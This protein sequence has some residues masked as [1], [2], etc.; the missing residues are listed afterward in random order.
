MD[1]CT[2]YVKAQRDYADQEREGDGI[3]QYAQKFTSTAGRHDG[4]YWPVEDGQPLS[5]LAGYRFR[6]LTRQGTHAPGGAYD[7]VINGHMVAGFA[8][9]AWP[10]RHGASGVMT[11]VVNQNGTVFQKDLGPDTAGAVE[12]MDAYDPDE[13]WTRQ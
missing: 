11:F 2:T 9:V 8:L 12:K 7:Y 3:I 6:I 13:T 5:P 1:F 4:L 10:V